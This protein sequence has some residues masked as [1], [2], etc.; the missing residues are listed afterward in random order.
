MST[1]A[2]KL[3]IVSTAGDGGKPEPSA[4]QPG[5]DIDEPDQVPE[6]DKAAGGDDDMEG[7]R[8]GPGADWD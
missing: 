5:G 1:L 3:T 8:G 6:G 7:T 2:E 4:P